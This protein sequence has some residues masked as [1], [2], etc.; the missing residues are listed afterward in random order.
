[1]KLVAE[2]N[3][4]IKE[5][6]DTIKDELGASENLAKLVNCVK[7]NTNE[8]CKTLADTVIKLYGK[9]S[10]VEA[11][12]RPVGSSKIKEKQS[13]VEKKHSKSI[14]ETKNNAA[15]KPIIPYPV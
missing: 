6:L 14:P 4:E 5:Q 3:A 7:N 13:S 1:M 10:K 9:I 15:P 2:Q 8:N 12:I 11:R